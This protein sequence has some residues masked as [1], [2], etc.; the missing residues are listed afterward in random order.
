MRQCINCRVTVNQVEFLRGSS[1]LWW[2]V[3]GVQSGIYTAAQV[4]YDKLQDVGVHVISCVAE[5]PLCVC[6]CVCVCVCL[7]VVCVGV[8]EGCSDKAAYTPVLHDTDMR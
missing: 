2:A 7:S 6:V 4:P 3:V 1:A 8:R 5:I